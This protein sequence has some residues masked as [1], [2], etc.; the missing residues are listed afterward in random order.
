M[1]QSLSYYAEILQSHLPDLKRQFGVKSL[2][3]FGSY[4]RGQQRS[5]SDLDVLVNFDELPS[6]VEFIN[7]EDRL[8]ELTGLEV[9]L[10]MEDGL[11]PNIDKR[12][13]KEVVHL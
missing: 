8:S 12:I 10:V 2:G 4:V 7:L 9:D 5:S 1:N 6:L 3:L 11:K 13:L